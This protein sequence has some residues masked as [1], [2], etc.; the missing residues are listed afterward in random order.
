M[1]KKLTVIFKD[2]EHSDDDFSGT[3][4]VTYDNAS[5]KFTNEHII[6]NLHKEGDNGPYIEGN[7]FKIGLIKQ[8]KGIYASN[9][10]N[11]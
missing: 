6:I 3:Y 11:S 8:Y 1:Y 10:T 5:L 4:D 7:I 2:S 9:T